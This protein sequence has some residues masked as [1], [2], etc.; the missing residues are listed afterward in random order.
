MPVVRVARERARP[1]ALS[2]VSPHFPASLH[3]ALIKKPQKKMLVVGAKLG[4]FLCA[5]AT[6]SK[7]QPHSETL[8][9]DLGAC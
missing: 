1:A 2:C 8:S 7:I 3:C 5:L 9:P 6:A 4:A